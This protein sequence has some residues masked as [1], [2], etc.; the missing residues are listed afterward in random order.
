MSLKRIMMAVLLY[1]FLFAQST[2]YFAKVALCAVRVICA[3][4]VRF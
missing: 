2:N 3:Q 4:K 1:K